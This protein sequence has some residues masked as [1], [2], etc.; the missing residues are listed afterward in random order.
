MGRPIEPLSGDERITVPL[1]SPAS[2][3]HYVLRVVGDSMNVVVVG[4]MRK[5]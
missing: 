5:F 2:G 4:L 3:D 1:L